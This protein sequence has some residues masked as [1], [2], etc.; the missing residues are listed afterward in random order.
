MILRITCVDAKR[1]ADIMVSYSILDDMLCGYIQEYNK[2]TGGKA[3]V[4]EVK[5]LS[6]G[7]ASLGMGDKID[8]FCKIFPNLED[9]DGKIIKNVKGRLVE[10]KT[11]RKRVAHD[12]RFSFKNGL[13]IPGQNIKSQK[14][15]PLNHLYKA[16]EDN[17]K[18]FD[19]VFKA[20]YSDW[21][22]REQFLYGIQ[23]GENL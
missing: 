6:T 7:K 15:P 14:T 16:Y 12:R 2:L 13:V 4:N 23:K 11:A 8:C 10:L 20:F 3:F 19:S 18:A 5:K 22:Y 9:M 17:F 21:D 1:I